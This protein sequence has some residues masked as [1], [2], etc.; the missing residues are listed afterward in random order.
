MASEKTG[1]H[2]L[3]LQEVKRAEENIIQTKEGNIF[4]YKGTTPRNKG[5]EFIVQ[6]K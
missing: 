2:I 4:Y 1:L 5:V 6:G 3:E